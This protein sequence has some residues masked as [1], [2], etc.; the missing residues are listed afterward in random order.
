MDAKVVGNGPSESARPKRHEIVVFWI[1]RDTACAECGSELGKGRFI[2]LEGEQALCLECADLDHLVFLPRGDTALTRRATKYS[3]LWAV[4]VR[5]S[6]SRK[7]YERQGVLV[8]ESALAR[9][10]RECL[11]DTEARALARERAA[12]RKAELDEEYIEAFAQHIGEFFPGCPLA[13]QHA[14]AE[15]ACRK[16]SGRI[17]RSAAGKRFEADAVNLALRAHVRHAHTRYD[18]FLIQGWGRGE[19]R[20][21]VE[22]KVDEVLRRWE[23][24]P[25]PR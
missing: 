17:G 13:E 12:E 24:K 9:A 4:V 22:S 15:H 8:E 3:T 20:A 25:P 1:I 19:A 7:R 11:A 14:I 23:A 16:Y 18:E 21:E 2:R 5:F 6:R 10:E